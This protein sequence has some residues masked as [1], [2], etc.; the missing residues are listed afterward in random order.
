MLHPRAPRHE[1]RSHGR[2]EIRVVVHKRYRQL[3][4]QEFERLADCFEPN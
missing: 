1:S 4:W 3:L 2:I